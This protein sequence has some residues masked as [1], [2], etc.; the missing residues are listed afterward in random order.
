MSTSAALEHVD[1]ARG[2][3]PAVE[4]GVKNPEKPKAFI[5]DVKDDAANS[6]SETSDILHGPNGETYPTKE[7]INTLRRV[8]GKI[9]WLIYSIGFVEMCERFAYYGTVA[10]CESR[11][12]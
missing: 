9:P 10:V 7:E 3:F 5:G 2:E 8:C 4:K 6:D 12:L 1:A 11:V